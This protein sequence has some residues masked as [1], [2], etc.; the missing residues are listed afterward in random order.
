[1]EV[2]CT[3]ITYAGSSVISVQSVFRAVRYMYKLYFCWFIRYSQYK[4]FS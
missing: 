4:V 1:M 3:N 2:D